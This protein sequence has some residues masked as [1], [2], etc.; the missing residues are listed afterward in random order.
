MKPENK[1]YVKFIG[2]NSHALLP[3][4]KIKQF[5]KDYSKLSNTKMK[6]LIASIK[7]AE[8]IIDSKSK[9]SR[10][11]NTNIEKNEKEDICRMIEVN[12][13]N[14]SIKVSTLK[15]RKKVVLAKKKKSKKNYTKSNKSE[16][17]YGIIKMR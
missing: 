9:S 7:L 3:E 1:F 14:P 6:K 2:D 12:Y 11:N 4:T 13:E 5:M 10:I 17:L 8:E 16:T 15:K